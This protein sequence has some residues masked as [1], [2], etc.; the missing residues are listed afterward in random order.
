MNSDE[1]SIWI[2]HLGVPHPLLGCRKPVRKLVQRLNSIFLSV[3][4]AICLFAEVDNINKSDRWCQCVRSRARPFQRSLCKQHNSTLI[5]YHELPHLSLF[6]LFVAFS[7]QMCSRHISGTTGFDGRTSPTFFNSSAYADA[8][9]WV[10][11]KRSYG[12][13]N[14][15]RLR[16]DG[17]QFGKLNREGNFNR[18]E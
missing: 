11:C 13:C 17:I 1:N 3:L 5:A 15:V 9:A 10:D 7:V 6:Y 8:A 16:R 4:N 14:W 18:F 2:L 12:D